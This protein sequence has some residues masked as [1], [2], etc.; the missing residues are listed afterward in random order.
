MALSGDRRALLQLLCERGQ[1]YDD[2]AG[3]LG[4]TPGEVRERARAALTELGGSDPDSEVGLTD[5]LLGQADPIGRADAVRHLQADP[6]AL[7]LATRIETALRLIAPDAKV[8]KL[9][10]P[11]GKRRRAAV[12][13]AGDGVDAPARTGDPGAVA[14]R[15]SRDPD[16]GGGGSRQ[17]AIFAGLAA[18][19]VILLVAILAIAGVFSSDGDAGSPQATTADPTGSTDSAA[20]TAAEPRFPEV[21]LAPSSNSNVAGTAKFGV[22]ANSQPFVDVAIGGLDPKADE[23]STYLLWMMIGDTGG[24]PIPRELTADQNGNFSGRL[25]IPTPA[26]AIVQEADA[27]R[28]SLSPLTELG[29]E[30]K[31]AANQGVPVVPF[32][33]AELASGRI[34]LAESAAG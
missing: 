9:P 14:A 10:E 34:P 26:I 7:D 31:K 29:K 12:P 28:V 4:G 11:R 30:V 2:I 33:G 6:E 21:E 24:F 16:G 23:K 27:I 13:A 22:V 32:T 19:A 1:S 15:S 18:G 25:A 5:Y 17:T 3:L 8:P 20:Q